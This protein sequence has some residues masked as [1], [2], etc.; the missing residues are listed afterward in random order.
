MKK[1][2]IA[3]F[4]QA[5][6]TT[7]IADAIAKGLSASEWEI[8]FY[9]MAEGQPVDLQAYDIIGIGSPTYFFQ[10]PF[11]VKEFVKQLADIKDKAS[12]VFVLYG[13]HPGKCG[14]W[15]REELKHKGTHDLGY[16][17]STGADYWH[18]YIKRGVMFSPDSPSPEDLS[19]AEIFGENIALRFATKDLAAEPYDGTTP[20]VYQIERMAVGQPFVKALYTKAF[21]ADE[22]CTNCGI[23]IQK[24]PTNNIIEQS[25][26]KL[27]WGSDC[28]FCAT[29]EL[30][31]P[32]NAIHSAF[33]WSIFSPFMSY[34]IAKSKKK[35]I[36]FNIVKHDK[37]KISTAIS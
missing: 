15:I 33:N 30:S 36:P 2:L 31:C 32:Q 7:K 22:N 20:F 1:A 11:L 27:N 8:T 26:K 23:C 34:N 6:A 24:C 13:T 29:C 3:T 10:P 35:G 4:S 19:S 12:F 9:N 17:K 18:G 25:D 37:G 28:L 5:G 16:F 21:R 14:N